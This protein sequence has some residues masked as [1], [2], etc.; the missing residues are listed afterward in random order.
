MLKQTLSERLIESQGLKNTLYIYR[1]RSL[2]LPSTIF[3]K[4]PACSPYYYGCYKTIG[5]IV[6][7]IYNSNLQIIL[8]RECGTVCLG[9]C[10]LMLLKHKLVVTV[11]MKLLLVQGAI[12]FTFT[13]R[14][15]VNGLLWF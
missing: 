6:R 3:K 7:L 15:V 14:N 5:N 9:Y 10:C 8:A 1:G 13:E 4:I 2:L 12:R 11:L